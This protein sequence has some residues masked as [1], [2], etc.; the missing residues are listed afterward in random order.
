MTRII[1]PWPPALLS[2][3]AKGNG[4]WAK[5]SATK[6]LRADAQ[7]IT[8]LADP[9]A[10]PEKGDI[11]I[12]IRFEAPDNRADR[13]NYPAR[14]K[15]LIDGLADALAVNDKRFLPTWEYGPLCPPHGRVVVEIGGFAV[16]VFE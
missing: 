9:P 12:K 5:I 8:L 2:G 6:K 4:Q 3:H 7:A 13:C 10:M 16:E 11:P 1:L 15:P 14:A